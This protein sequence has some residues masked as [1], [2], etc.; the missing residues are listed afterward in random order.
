MAARKIRGVKNLPEEWKLK[1]KATALVNRL[2]DC[3]LGEA[4]M[5]SQ[6]IKAADI[7]LKKVAPD[8]AR[9]EHT[10]KD[11]GPQEYKITKVV[12]SARDTD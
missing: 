11:G 6:Q 4:E 3:A 10:G 2:M 1:I 12:H 9:S 5:D 8:L 7:L